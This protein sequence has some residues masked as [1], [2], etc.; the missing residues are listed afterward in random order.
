MRY[1]HDVQNEV[2]QRLLAKA[3]TTAWGEQYGYANLQGPHD[4]AEQVPLNTYEDLFPWIQ[5]SMEG[6]SSVLWPGEI[7]WF[8]KSSGSGIVLVGHVT[9]EGAIAGPRLLEHIVDTV[10]YFEGERHHSHRVVRAV[11]NRFG[12]IS[13][14]GV[15][16]MTGTGL[17]S[18][19]S[20]GEDAPQPA[21]SSRAHAPSI[22]ALGFTT[23]HRSTLE[24]QTAG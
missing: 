24:L 5:R 12:A 23:T 6:E 18:S 3:K 9:K 15:F 20:W 7:R 8:A 2:L 16:E 4:F 17:R 14:L 10:L 11:K 1:P 19:P 22:S 13:E 21:A